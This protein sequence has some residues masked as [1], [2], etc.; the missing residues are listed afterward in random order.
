MFFIIYTH[1]LPCTSKYLRWF[2]TKA[3][4]HTHNEFVVYFGCRY[5]R[6]GQTIQQL[7]QEGSV[8]CDE[9]TLVIQT[10]LLKLLHDKDGAL[11]LHFIFTAEFHINK[12]HLAL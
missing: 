6:M 8:R 7:M 9:E 3:P 10:I 11:L 12:E 4:L 1:T 5:Q 2:H